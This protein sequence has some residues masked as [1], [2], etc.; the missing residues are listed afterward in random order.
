MLNE[1]DAKYSYMLLFRSLVFA[2]VVLG[3]GLAWWAGT[4]IV[5]IP[6]SVR[7]LPFLFSLGCVF[8]WLHLKKQYELFREEVESQI[9]H[10]DDQEK[11]D[12]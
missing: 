2:S 9:K 12:E 11:A 4:A 10:P 3:L 6:Y 5:N 7:L 8:A 1:K